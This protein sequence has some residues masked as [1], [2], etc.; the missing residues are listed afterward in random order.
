MAWEGEAR[1][2]QGILTGVGVNYPPSLYQV[3]DSREG[4]L[5]YLRKGKTW[6]GLKAFLSPQGPHWVAIDKADRGHTPRP[7]NPWHFLRPLNSQPVIS[8]EATHPYP[9]KLQTPL[10]HPLS[11]QTSM[12]LCHCSLCLGSHSLTNIILPTLQDPGQGPSHCPVHSSHVGV[13]PLSPHHTP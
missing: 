4:S 7:N 9:L 11:H 3:V 2:A 6:R 13:S 1:G 8:P 10:H 12:S 5:Y